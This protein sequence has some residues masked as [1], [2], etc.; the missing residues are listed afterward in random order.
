MSLSSKD[1]VLKPE[2]GESRDPLNLSVSV[3][4]VLYLRNKLFSASEFD[5]NLEHM[6]SS[7]GQLEAGFGTQPELTIKLRECRMLPEKILL[8]LPKEIREKIHPLQ[9][10]GPINILGNVSARR[11][12][13]KG[14][15]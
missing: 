14:T 3:K 9:L 4:G 10:S 1:I 11:E 12:E 13:G 7:S 8:F 2:T 5:F 15:K 6:I